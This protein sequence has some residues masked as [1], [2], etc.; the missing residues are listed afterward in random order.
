MWDVVWPES[1]NEY[2]QTYYMMFYST[3]ERDA[4]RNQEPLAERY[5][6]FDETLTRMESWL[7]QKGWRRNRCDR[8]D[9]A[10]MDFSCVSS[11]VRVKAGKKK[12]K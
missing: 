11:V 7:L 8:H 9:E 12:K 1:L 4:I 5:S 10:C 6:R 2:W 3:K